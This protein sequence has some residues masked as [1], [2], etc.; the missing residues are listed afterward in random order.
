MTTEFLSYRVWPKDWRCIH[1][2]IR[3]VG[4]DILE[5]VRDRIEVFD[6]GDCGMVWGEFRTPKCKPHT[7]IYCHNDDVS[8]VLDCVRSARR[9]EGKDN[10]IFR[11]YCVVTDPNDWSVK[12]NKIKWPDT[13]CNYHG[14]KV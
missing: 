2:M 14:G 6:T 12:V 13:T 3:P 10:M 7:Q 8:D 4:Y 5:P 9:K 1:A 11:Y